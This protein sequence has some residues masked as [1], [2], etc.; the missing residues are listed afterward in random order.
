MKRLTLARAAVAAAVL[1]LLLATGCS[2]RRSNQFTEQG[3]TY[4]ALGNVDEA[5][6]AFEQALELNPKNA[7]AKLGV[8]RTLTARKQYDAA[9]AAYREAIALDPSL[10]KA[11]IEGV[12]AALRKDDVQDAEALAEEYAK[13]NAE[14]GGVLRA[15]VL[16]E[17]GRPVEA[18]ALLT[19]LRGQHPQSVELPVH[20]A[21]AYLAANQPAEA[22]RE[23]KAVLEQ[24][25]AD[26]LPARMLLIDAYQAQGKVAEIESE[27]RQM[28]AERPDDD[29]LQL[30][31]ARSLLANK[32]LDEAEAIARPILDKTPE[33]PWANYV[34]GACLLARGKTA[35]SLS[36]LQAAAGAL[37]DDPQIARL[38]AEAQQGGKVA[39]A[40]PTKT[41]P[42]TALAG[43]KPATTEAQTWQKLWRDASLR[44]LLVRREEYLQSQDPNV[45]ETL[46][47]AAVFVQEGPLARQL[48]ERLPADSH[49]AKYIS[50]LLSRDAALVRGV[51]DAWQES[52]TKRRVLRMN[53]EGFALAVAGARAQALTVYS[54]CLDENPDNGVAYY[55]V[56]NMFRSAGMPKFAIGALRRLIARHSDNRE[57]R[58]L[59]FDTMLDANLP[60]EARR[61]A[62]STFA[63]FPDDP[64]SLLNLAR[65]YRDAGEMGLAE[66]V[67]RKGIERLDEKPLLTLAL[68]ELQVARGEYDAA[69]ELLKSLSGNERAKTQVALLS[70]FIA[71][72]R[73]DW[74]GALARCEEVAGAN[75]PGA[76][77][78]LHSAA[79]LRAGKTAEAADPLRTPEGQFRTGPTVNII[80]RALGMTGDALER[81]DEALAEKLKASP[82]VLGDFTFGMAL[83]EMRFSRQA[84]ETLRAVDEKMPAEPRLVELILG[85]LA[86]ANTIP[87]RVKEAAAYTEKYPKLAAAWIGLSDVHAALGNTEQ[88]LAA[89]EQATTAEPENDQAWR[90]LGQYYAARNDYASLLNVS[91]RIVGIMPDDPYAGN[92]LAYCILQTG[93]D[94]NEALALA[95]SASEKLPRHPDVAHT[96]GLA[97]M[98][99]GQLEEGRKNLAMALEMRPGDPTLMLDYGELLI[100]QNE[101]EEGR[102]HIQ[103]ALRYANDLGLEFP[104]KSEA[105][106]AV[107]EGNL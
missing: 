46:A 107:A 43:E 49:V 103:H 86:R 4:L 99:L 30:A 32:K 81:N 7:A 78:L 21:V 40:E 14:G 11:Y 72:L 8:A 73:N 101:A 9:L 36:C 37:P 45:A 38:L 58:Q 69:E 83:R 5:S 33:S 34:V 25:G 65:V 19:Q 31:L 17:T 61:Q 1:C 80:V 70:S 22:E 63:L 41:E 20:L 85:T 82:E 87:D 89:L 29:T 2:E 98:R 88:Q 104:R 52:D 27:F 67:L 35:E 13:V 59:L 77:R 24:P 10:D 54:K 71:A 50:A 91:R 47:L 97:Q 44:A 48:T 56:A 105:E 92:N 55:N 62:E 28:A 6:R 102:E 66:D 42:Q 51:L 106:K 3:N 15:Y 93:G 96:L 90:R 64:A 74:D 53:A 75:Y 26:S 79:L 18:V 68:A 57:A 12:K 95:K 39:A 23:L 60:D 16:R 100:A 76:M 94:A 84:Y